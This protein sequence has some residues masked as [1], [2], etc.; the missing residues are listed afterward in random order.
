MLRFAALLLLPVSCCLAGDWQ[1]TA[2]A[3][4][5][6]YHPVTFT[7][8]AG[9]AQAGIGSRYVLH[10]SAGRQIGE[11]FAIEA[12]WTFQDGDFELASGGVKTAFDAHSHAV[13]ADLL[14]YLRKRSSRLRPYLVGGAGAKFYQ[15]I[16][17]PNPRP[18]AQFGFFRDR[19]DARALLTFGGG[20]EW[21]FSR[22]I[23][24]RVDARDYATPFPTTVITPVPGAN[25]TGWFHDF[26]AVV[27]IT[28][29]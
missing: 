6:A 11:R 1:A 9:T 27:G 19:V 18:L 10:A 8:P 26:V 4:F 25:L 21:G 24:F 28:L 29:R 2:A 14:G 20:V 16:E 7:A 13:H 22:H 12:A 23:A 17:K 3:G 15:G 5:G